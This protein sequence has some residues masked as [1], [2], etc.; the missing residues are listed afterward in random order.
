MYLCQQLAGTLVALRGDLRAEAH[1]RR[2]QTPLDD[3]LQ[4]DERTAANEQ[5]VRR[6]DLDEFLM[7]M[8]APALR[9]NVG[10]GAFEDL[11]QRL[12]HA[13]SGDIASDRWVVTFAA[14]LIDLVDVDDA[15]L[16]FLFVIAGG[17]IQLE[18]D[19]LHILTD[20]A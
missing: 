10:D 13:L 17:L 4:S 15:P 16:R 20:V 7:R 11:Q 6:V 1:R 12:L 2:G 3:V 9:R 14:D 19:V 5:D 8:L 18:D